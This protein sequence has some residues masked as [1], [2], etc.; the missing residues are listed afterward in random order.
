MK[1]AKPITVLLVEDHA[2]VRKGLRALL[3]ADGQFIIAGEA[4]NGRAGVALAHKLRPDVILM[5]I[6]MPALN[7]LEAAHQILAANPAA[8]VIMLSAH[9][10]DAYVEYASMT[11]VAGFLA[12]QSSA[13]ILAEAIR[14]VAKGGTFFSPAI[15]KRM[16]PDRDKP[17]DR[18]GALKAAGAG[19][20]P[21]ES[22]V[23]RQVAGGSTNKQ[24]AA[25]L[26][27]SIRMVE[28][29]LQCL[30]RKLK[31]HETAGLIRWSI[32]AGFIENTVQLTIV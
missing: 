2:I 11:G 31:I 20:T 24:V 4:E 27:I 3:K 23:L 8:K 26:G 7:G 29:H 1:P 21:R 25:I 18:H 10:D 19:L 15:A 13:D 22:K 17:R 5:D 12:K 32:A 30:M 16:P 6:A 14:E 28:R 9:T